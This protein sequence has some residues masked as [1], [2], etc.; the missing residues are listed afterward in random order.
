MM[1]EGSP[2]VEY[3]LAGGSLYVVIDGERVAQAPAVE[4]EV[5]VDTRTH[6]VNLR[7]SEQTIIQAEHYMTP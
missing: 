4:P 7:H 5:D 6:V 3:L 1:G 2:V